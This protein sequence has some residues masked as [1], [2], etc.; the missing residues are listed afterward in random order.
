M[1]RERS[2][3]KNRIKKF[4]VLLMVCLTLCGMSISAY[5]AVPDE[6]VCAFSFMGV[7]CY[8]R[9]HISYHTYVDG[10]GEEHT[11]EVYVESYR[12]VYKCACGAVEYRNYRGVAK[13]TGQCG[14]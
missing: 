11:C 2:M 10:N 3:K 9:S 6:H 4:V 8:S 13:H 12:D 14:Q 1:W 5:A 7:D